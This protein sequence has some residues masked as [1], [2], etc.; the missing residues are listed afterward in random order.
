MNTD[1]AIKQRSDGKFELTGI[2]S[3]FTVPELIK[4]ARELL[5][6]VEDIKI[7][8]KGV[9]RSDSAGVAL[10]VEWMNEANRTNKQILFMNIPVQM[11]AIA[12]VSSLDQVLPLSREG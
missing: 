5:D 8:L 10:L 7:D 11:L 2:L 4:P 9:V 1:A 3:F 6:G 12:R